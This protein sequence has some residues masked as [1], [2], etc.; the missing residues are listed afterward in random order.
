MTDAWVAPHLNGNRCVVAARH[1]GY[2][3][4][5]YEA[6]EIAKER[7][8]PHALVYVKVNAQVAAR[9]RVNLEDS[10]DATWLAGRAHEHL[11]KELA[12]EHTRKAIETD[13]NDFFDGVWPQWMTQYAPE[14]MGGA[15]ERTEI[16]M[17]IEDLVVEQGGTMI[18]AP[19]GRG[20]SYVAMLL[21]VSAQFGNNQLFRIPKQANSLYVNLERSRESMRQRLGNVNEVLG[22]DRNT[23]HHFLNARGRGLADVYDSVERY[24]N[25]N[26]IEFVVLDSISRAGYS[27]SLTEDVTSNRITDALNGLGVTWLGLGH[28]PRADDTHEYGSIMFRAGVDVMVILNSQ[29]KPDGTMGI[30]LRVDKGN[31]IGNVPQTIIG[32]AFDEKGLVRAWK[33]RASEFPEVAAGKETND[34]DVIYDYIALAGSAR[35]IQI[36][37]ETGLAMQKIG[38]ILRTDTRRFVRQISL[39]KQISYRLAPLPSHSNWEGD[40]P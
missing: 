23:A 40:R 9:S 18:V 31:D 39:D 15:A 24:V 1:F 30:G 16:P 35:P 34:S 4:V 32:L 38:Q 36:A 29:Q 25:D 3:S 14:L 37:R 20:K 33:A 17:L 26:R 22:M 6:Y 13:L 11:G 8:R 10:K 19:P 2:A 28:T 12:E 5:T 21:Q 27:G 7:G